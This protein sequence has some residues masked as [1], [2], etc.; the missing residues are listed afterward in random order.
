MIIL[1]T[2]D[3]ALCTMMVNISMLLNNEPSNKLWK[4]K[5]INLFIHAV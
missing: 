2:V 5:I 4:H 1:S 3:L